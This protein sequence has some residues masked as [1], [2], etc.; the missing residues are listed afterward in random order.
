VLRLE[1]LLI[2]N[3]LKLKFMGFFDFGLLMKGDV[4][5]LATAVIIGGAL[6]K[7]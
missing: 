4:L 6:G 5:S 3:N 7:L 2:L 1:F